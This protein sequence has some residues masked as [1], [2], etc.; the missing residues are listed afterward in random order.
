MSLYFIS[1][2]EHIE[3]T[4]DEGVELPDLDALRD[5]LRRTLSAILA[6]EGERTGVN[7]FTAR[8]YDEDGRLVMRAQTSFSTEDQ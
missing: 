5:L 7:A 2:A 3:V 4:E 1:T 8:A 6:D